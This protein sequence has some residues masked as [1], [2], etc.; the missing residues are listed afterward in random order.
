MYNFGFA[1]EHSLGHITHYQNLRRW[2]AEDTDI[3]PVWM[4]IKSEINDLWEHFPVISKNWSL[5]ASLRTRDALK[6]ALT[7]SPLDVVFLHT[8][9]LALFAIPFMRHI[10]TIISTDATPLNYDT[11]GSGYKHQVGGNALVERY[12]F[13]WNKSTY[14]AATLL[15]TWCQWAKGSLVTDYGISP[16]KVTVIPP[17][18]DLQQWRF[19]RNTKPVGDRLRLLFVGGDFARKGGYTLLS[20]FRNGLNY[21]CTLDIVTKDTNIQQEL[22]GIEGVRVHC[23]LTPNSAALKELYANADTFVFPTQG[24]CFPLAVI[25]AMA[26]GLPI[27]GTDVGALREQVEDGVSGF[28]VSPGDVGA[29]ISAVRALKNDGTKRVAMAAASRYKAEKCFDARRNYGTIFS[30][31]KSISK[32]H[33]LKESKTTLYA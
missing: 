17:G 19:G 11:V 21:D 24:D 9:T 23:G 13:L 15:V 33:I 12:K 27:I 20:A 5:Q 16:E 14:H 18:V 4:P 3:Y 6:A 2:V 7:S 28:V 10:P 8:Q 26:A 25:E 31:M 22:V 32:R 30:L 1:V 29:L